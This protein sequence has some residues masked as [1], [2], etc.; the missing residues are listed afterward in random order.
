M[1]SSSECQGSFDSEL[2]L[3]E[4]VRIF[5]N[6]I[7]DIANIFVGGSDTKVQLTLK[8]LNSQQIELK[9]L[10]IPSNR[11]I[12]LSVSHLK[13]GMYFVELKSLEVQ[14]ELKLIKA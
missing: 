2:F 5:P 7:K 12:Q 4:D 10:E 11:I 3:S 1:T 8:D 13:T 6:P 14:K 9:T